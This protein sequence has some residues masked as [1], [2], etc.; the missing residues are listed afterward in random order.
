[1]KTKRR[2]PAPTAAYLI[3][4]LAIFIL[5]F[6]SVPEYSII[7]NT[8]CELGAQFSPYAWIMNFTFVLLATVIVI[9]GWNYYES[10][11]LHRI[12]LV[13]L[14]I[15]LVLTG[16]FNHAPVNPD[17]EYNITEAGLHSYF[18]CTTVISFIIL[19]IAT[20]FIMDRQYERILAI[21]AGL[22]AIV[23]SV[24]TSE[25]D[26]LAG[27]WG[28]LLFMISSAWMIYNLRSREY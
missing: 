1:M 4:L 24:L 6:F 5:P 14:G 20:G 26:R 11:T 18:A 23:L 7:R 15:S 19:S 16:Y 12:L 22:S 2:I 3:M 10:F 17:T 8:I 27:I 28:R 25:S 21:A 13:I 9:A